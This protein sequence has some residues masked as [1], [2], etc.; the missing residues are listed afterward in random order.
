MSLS[1]SFGLS[2]VDDELEVEELEEED[3]LGLGLLVFFFG[4]GGSIALSTIEWI[5]S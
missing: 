4:F 3:E 5:L 2:V 1:S